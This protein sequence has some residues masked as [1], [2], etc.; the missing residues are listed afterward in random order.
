MMSGTENAER[1][2]LAS[3]LLTLMAEGLLSYPAERLDDTRD[4]WA[5]V[6]LSSVCPALEEIAETIAANTSE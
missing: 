2:R 3:K 1:L 6:L 4:T 5:T